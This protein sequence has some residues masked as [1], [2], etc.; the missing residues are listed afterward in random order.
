MPN[1]SFTD[2]DCDLSPS[3]AFQGWEAAKRTLA[4]SS[5]TGSGTDNTTIARVISSYRSPIT[6]ALVARSLGPKGLRNHHS[7]SGVEL[8]PI[9]MKTHWNLLGDVVCDIGS[10]KGTIPLVLVPEGLGLL[11]RCYSPRPQGLELL[12]EVLLIVLSRQVALLM[13]LPP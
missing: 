11:P 4:Q 13:L 8:R 6:H 10:S 9:W 1:S 12:G 5:F 2:Y 3:V 7:A